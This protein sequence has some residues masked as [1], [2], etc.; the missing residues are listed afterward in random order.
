[1]ISGANSTFSPKSELRMIE[2]QESQHGEGNA[3]GSHAGHS[4]SSSEDPDACRMSGRT[5]GEACSLQSTR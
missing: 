1:M 3:Q 5:W 4:Q 2:S